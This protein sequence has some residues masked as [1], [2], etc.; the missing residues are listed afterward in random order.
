MVR[1][2][3]RRF[4]RVLRGFGWHAI[5][6]VTFLSSFVA[7]VLI[8]LPLPPSRRVATRALTVQVSK[9]IRGSIEVEQITRLDLAG[10]EASG[11]TI[12]DPNG[13]VVLFSPRL[14]AHGNLLNIGLSLMPWSDTV[15]IRSTWIRA[16]Q[17]DLTF[18]EGPDG[19]PTLSTTF[20]PP[21]KP[22][23]PPTTKPAAPGRPV[24]VELVGIEIGSLAANGQLGGLKTVD[25]EAKSIRG[26]VY[27]GPGGV[28]ID[29]TAFP[30]M[31]RRILPEPIRTTVDYHFRPPVM[32]W[33][34]IVAGYEQ[35]VVTG[36]AKLDH[37]N[38]ELTFDLPRSPGSV[39]QGIVPDAIRLTDAVE[40]K[41]EAKGDLPLLEAHAVATTGQ[42]LL[43]ARGPVRL[44]PEFLADL[45]VT[46]KRLNLSEVVVGA[47]PTDLSADAKV[48]VVLGDDALPR[49]RVQGKTE[50]TVF[51]DVPLPAADVEA[52]VDAGGVTGTALL[53]EP[54]MVV[55]ADFSVSEAGEV[56][57]AAVTNV[58]SLLEVPR[59]NRI[60]GGYAVARVEGTYQSGR[61]DATLTADAG[62]LTREGVRLGT[63]DVTARATGKLDDLE[64]DATAFGGQVRAAGLEW[65][66]FDASARGPVRAPS[67]RVTLSDEHTPNVV[68]KAGLR[69]G[70]GLRAQNVVVTLDKAGES[71]EAR[72]SGIELRGAVVDFG[73]VAIDGLGEPVD[74]VV[75]VSP[76]G[77]DVRLVSDGVALDKLSR[78]LGVDTPRLEGEAA[79]DVDLRNVN[80]ETHGCARI[81]VSDARVE[82]FDAVDFSMRA[83]FA[84]THVEVDTGLSV[85][86]TKKG[87][88]TAGSVGACLPARP[89]RG[90]GMLEA[91]AT[92]N[93]ALRGSPVLPASWK[94]A[95]GTARLV[96]LMVSLDRVGRYLNLFQA[97]MPDLE[98][99]AVGGTIFA[100]GDVVRDDTSGP[101][102]WTLAASTKALSVGLGKGNETKSIHGADLFA[103]ASMHQ[104]G[105]L[106][107]S[108]CV[109]DDNGAFDS[110]PC[111]PRETNVLASVGLLAELDYPALFDEPSR[112]RRILEEA[113][114]DARVVVHNRPV[115]ALLRPLPIEG[116]LPVDAARAS[117]SV[118][119]RGTYAEPSLDYRIQ[120]LDAGVT[121]PDWRAPATVCA[122]G[123]Y[124]GSL[125]VLN[126]DL[127]RRG[128]AVENVDLEALCHQPA[129]PTNTPEGRGAPFASMGMVSANLQLAWQDVLAM[130]GR[131]KI[132]WLANVNA[133]I[134]GFELSDVPL[135]A[136][137]G[138]SGRLRLSGGVA[139]LGAH[140]VFGVQ[141]EVDGLNTGD[142][143]VYERSHLETHTDETGFSGKLVLSA[144]D[145]AGVPVDRLTLDVKTEQLKWA[146][147]WYPTQDGSKPVR[148]ELQADR[149]KIAVL[150]PLFHPVLSYV[151]GEVRGL[152]HVVW[153]PEDG[154]STVEKAYLELQHGAFQIPTIG[155][156]F[157]DVSGMVQAAG[158]NRLYVERF[159]ARSLSGAIVARAN[160]DL[161]GFDIAHVG[162]SLSTNRD[163]QIRLTFEGIPVG[164]LWG[165]VFVAI[166]PRKD[167]YDATVE[168]KDI[169]LDLTDT[170]LRT[171]Q[172]LDPNPDVE[173]V[174][175]PEALSVKRDASSPF[176]GLGGF[177]DP[178]EEQKG[179]KPWHVTLRTRNPAILKR[180]GMNFM[181]VTPPEQRDVP[182]LVYPDPAT[183]E[184]T[185][186][187]HVILYD[188]RVDV[189]GKFFDLE[190]NKARVIFEGDPG[191]PMLNVTARWD[192]SDGTRVYA[193]VTGPLR[194]PRVQLRSDPAKPQSEILA[195]ILFGAQA[196]EASG[197]TE[198]GPQSGENKSAA[199]GVGGG[200]AAA[201]I[202]MLLEDLSPVNISTRIDTSR[203]QTPSPTLVV[204]VSRDVTAEATYVA[205]Q[206]L[207][208]S[209]RYFLT[210]DWRFMRQWSLRVTR[211]N[212]GTSILDVI[213]QHRY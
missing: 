30:L 186:V 49:F 1:S 24:V 91:R 182:T 211:G 109:R 132:P 116:P 142:G 196:S 194:D 45:Q 126:A 81:D 179:P 20:L 178:R 177:S 23:E 2:R 85:G 188:G 197:T 200:V 145:S 56:R 6:V 202:N 98:L 36:N 199:A 115:S 67:V 61:L 180:T 167:R 53:H 191:N 39:L 74:G 72:T 29:T 64:V 82:L 148:V 169:H 176:G 106:T 149:F 26:S 7:G 175:S 38:L 157:L 172:N 204:E 54:G 162:A 131:G 92:A 156:E 84:G 141:A 206:T 121:D 128:A 48:A 105:L 125:V 17:I 127:R 114:L 34:Q 25:W 71:V 40:G 8:H 213:W 163:N 154:K 55:Q 113:K 159:T 68:A 192:A 46:V 16:E 119:L 135:F 118:T 70:D 133:S 87:D 124:D 42:M 79:L 88:V 3:I 50:P 27:A 104:G 57:F 47:P 94:E 130:W 185:L 101:P 110:E 4:V 80:D 181:L 122:Q 41:V 184:A 100:Q 212:A 13:D 21:F 31:L 210:F 150:S 63:A 209:D 139:G 140:P 173:V 143:F 33:S 12:R 170:D 65:R 52:L 112:W 77:F 171:V 158:S 78:V 102:A 15:L 111:D 97:I 201:G 10:V 120:L 155:Q 137:S 86:G 129:A 90:E 123:S 187:G 62:N 28:R 5:V 83:L 117:A 166:E 208:Q 203:G 37:A 75:R 58:P 59:L 93:L 19:V 95:T 43:D 66:K 147:G 207:D 103:F 134:Y 99:P 136:D 174:P 189:L 165:D 89:V 14:Q 51:L 96:H 32:M 152:A 193:D 183:G 22:P 168:F 107:T 18:R 198:T 108:M 195:M 164:D 35:L 69:L 60:A 9:V 146:D 151:D 76:R 190:E 160:I 144:P 138:I 11:V 161:D 44:A 153:S 73:A 205:E